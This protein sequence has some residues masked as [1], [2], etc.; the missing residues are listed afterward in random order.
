MT[1]FSKGLNFKSVGALVVSALLLFC[2]SCTEVNDNLGVNIVPPG[3]QLKV[4]FTSLSEGFE[5]YLTYTDSVATSSLDYAY[6]G[7]M[8]D[9]HYGGKTR[10]AAMVQ[11]SYSLRTDTIAY[12]ERAS[13]PDSLALLLGMKTLGGDTLKRQQFDVYRLRKLLERDSVY[14]NGIDYESY[15]DSRPMFTCEFSG[16]PHGANSFDTLSLKV[17]DAALAEEFMQELWNDTTLY[18]TD[19]LFLEKFNGLCLVPSGTSPEDAAIYGLNLQWSTDEGPMSYL[20]AY[21]HDYP[22]GDDP[23]LV[24]DHIMRAFVISNNQSYTSLKAVS[25]IRHDYS[26]TLYGADVNINTTAD[27]PLQSPVTEGYVQGALGVTTTLEF[28]D[29]FVASLRALVP[30]GGE[31]FINQAKMS[32]PLAE[33]DYTF[34]DY[35]PARLGT[36]T[37][38]AGIVAV[39]DYG[40]YYEANYDAELVYGGYLNR[41]F[42]CYEVDLS[43]YLQQ[44]LHDEEGEVSRRITFGMAAYDYLDYAMVKLALDS[45]ESPL[46]FDITYTVIGK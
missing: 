26:A 39:P 1:L 16:R 41:T 40:Y 17:A 45:Q 4:E 24:E 27:E 12:E 22:K 21:G 6:F 8:T 14:Y 34:Y 28:G 44:L 9:E 38:Y 7:Q 43:L 2:A 37:N 11:F 20:V 25:S 15:I 42:G 19:S 33:Q 29:E 3:Q 46:K 35:A 5:G 18:A 36:Y 10:A 32:I 31:I 23:S 30:E 13:M